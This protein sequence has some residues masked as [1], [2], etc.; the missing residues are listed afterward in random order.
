MSRKTKSQ[1]ELEYA[2]LLA[3]GL[4]NVLND[5]FL[6]KI[7]IE[8]T[9]HDTIITDSKGDDIFIQNTT[10]HGESLMQANVNSMMLKKG[11]KF[12]PAFPVRYEHWIRLAIQKKHDRKYSNQESLILL[13]EGSIPSPE[14]ERVSKL[15]GKI[16]TPFLGIYYVS[17]PN[18]YQPAYIVAIKKFW[19]TP[20]IFKP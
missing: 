9:D 19:K 7:A 5:K 4:S 2:N 3:V 20:T 16:E 14:P 10:T 15:A 8:G 18:S 1:S 11:A 6:A 17:F 12:L 13:L